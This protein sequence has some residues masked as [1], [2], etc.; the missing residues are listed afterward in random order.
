MEC[1]ATEADS[2]PRRKSRWLQER[3]YGEQQCHAK[4]CQ[5]SLIRPACT[6]TQ[7]MQ[8]ASDGGKG[9]TQT[10]KLQDERRAQG[11]AV[12]AIGANPPARPSLDRSRICGT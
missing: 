6:S 10:T 11:G 4:R 3:E 9:Q 5:H 12:P 7:H 8:R 1:A 2:R